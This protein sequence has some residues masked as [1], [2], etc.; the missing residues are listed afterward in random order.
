M[1]RARKLCEELNAIVRVYGRAYLNYKGASVTVT[2]IP[3]DIVIMSI[4]DEVS[5]EEIL[6]RILMLW[7]DECDWAHHLVP[8]YLWVIR[9]RLWSDYNVD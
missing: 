8:N 2:N 6:D 5:E 7:E 1:S 9:D 3:K 4:S